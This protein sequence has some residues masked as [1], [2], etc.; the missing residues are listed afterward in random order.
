MIMDRTPDRI[1]LTFIVAPP[2]K[3]WAVLTNAAQSP[4]WFFAQRMDVGAAVGDP[5]LITTP[6]GNHPVKGEVLAIDP[7]RRLRVSWNVQ[8]PGVPRNEIEYLIE[9]MGEAS[10]LT[11]HE[12]HLG[13]VPE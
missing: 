8:M 6:D 7:P 10:K 12:Y 5:F 2:E 11:V 4:D 13:E 9:D 1:F 3:I